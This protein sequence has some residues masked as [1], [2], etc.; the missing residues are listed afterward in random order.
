MDRSEDRPYPSNRGEGVTSA[1]RKA[2]LKVSRLHPISTVLEGSRI[3]DIAYVIEGLA[4]ELIVGARVMEF[5]DIE[6]DPS[7]NR[8]IVGKVKSSIG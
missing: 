2:K 5:Y 1:D 4:E 3:D 6:L 7:T 8:I